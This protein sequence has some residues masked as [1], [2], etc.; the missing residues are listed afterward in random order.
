MNRSTRDYTFTPKRNSFFVDGATFHNG[1][2]NQ[3]SIVCVTDRFG[4]VLIERSIGNK[5][6]NE[7]ELIAIY[8]AIRLANQPHIYSD[9]QLAVNLLQRQY[10][11]KIPRLLKIIKEI[12]RLDNTFT[13][14]WIPREQNKAGHYLEKKYAL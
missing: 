10:S 5:T 13:I 1:A 11:T 6:N 8:E 7:A 14:S 9:S 2:P 12:D 3:S 4:K